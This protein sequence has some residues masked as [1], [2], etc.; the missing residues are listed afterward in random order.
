MN[1][2][3][4]FKSQLDLIE[5]NKFVF[6]VTMLHSCIKHKYCA[7]YTEKPKMFVEQ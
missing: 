3:V 6:Q 2:R 1:F 5:I 7:M 4:L